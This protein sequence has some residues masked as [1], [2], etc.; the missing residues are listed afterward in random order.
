MT[1]R[2]SND[3]NIKNQIIEEKIDSR[4]RVSREWLDAHGFIPLKEVRKSIEGS[5][6]VG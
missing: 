6:Y 2:N 5:N 4:K 1:K 3:S